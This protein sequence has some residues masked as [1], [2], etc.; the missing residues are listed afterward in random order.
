[1][2]PSSW[3]KSVPAALTMGACFK[4]GVG[5]VYVVPDSVLAWQAQWSQFGVERL[6]QSAHQRLALLAEDIR[7]ETPLEIYISSGSVCTGILDVAYQQKV[8]LVVLASHR[9]AMKDHLIGAIAERVARYAPVS[10]MVVR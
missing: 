6:L 3:A 9:P 1:M 8:D 10:V 5:L 7:R 4:S 2:N